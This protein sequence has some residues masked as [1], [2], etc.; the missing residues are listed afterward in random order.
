MKAFFWSVCFLPGSTALDD[1]RLE[2]SVAVEVL[3]LGRL[4]HH[5]HGRVGEGREALERHRAADRDLHG[6]VDDDRASPVEQ[7]VGEVE[8]RTL[9]VVVLDVQDRDHRV[10][11][12]PFGVVARPERAVRDTCEE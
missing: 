9:P 7:A 5:E 6:I 12:A 2:E 10:H 4:V 3:A 8:D 11:G 1:L